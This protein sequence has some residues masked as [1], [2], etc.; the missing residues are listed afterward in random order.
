MNQILDEIEG[1]RNPSNTFSKLSFGISIV[2][3]ALFGYLVGDMQSQI[4][5]SEAIA[6]PS[7]ILIVA[8][9]VFPLG[10]VAVA[11][12]SF[13]RKEPS[14]WMKWVGGILNSLLFVLVI[15]LIILKYVMYL[16]T[17]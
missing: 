8:I 16:A 5:V 15:G 17:Q 4:R 7:I 9:Y 1:N 3:L 6:V 12:L 11:F 13:F 14:N 10:G 2:T